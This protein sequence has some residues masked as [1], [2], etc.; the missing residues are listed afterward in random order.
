M[1]PRSPRGEPLHCPSDPAEEG[2]TPTGVLNGD[3]SIGHLADE[4]EI[5][6]G[7]VE[8]ARAGSAPEE[9]FRFAS[10][11]AEEK[12]RQWRDSRCSVPDRI[13]AIARDPEPPPTLP[14][15]SIRRRCR[16]FHQHG[17]ASRRS[18]HLMTI[19]GPG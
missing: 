10:P 18:C 8:T 17:Q 14:R 12:C 6:S 7:F 3:G 11:R 15:C 5:A 1:T 4:V 2:A 19:S 13:A 9:H 16:W